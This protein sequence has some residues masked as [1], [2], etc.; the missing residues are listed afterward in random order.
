M[1]IFLDAWVDENGQ[2]KCSEIAPAMLFPI[3]WF[4]VVGVRRKN[5]SQM[6]KLIQKALCEVQVVMMVFSELFHHLKSS[7]CGRLFPRLVQRKGADGSDLPGSQAQS[8][9]GSSMQTLTP[10]TFFIC[11]H[12]GS[13]L[14]PDQGYSQAT[15]HWQQ[16][17][18]E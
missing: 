2:R 13:S 17:Q 11:T 6:S 7:M 18:I 15:S 12:I 3:L 1:E 9:I 8:T 5:E 14:A 4:D 16:L 10:C